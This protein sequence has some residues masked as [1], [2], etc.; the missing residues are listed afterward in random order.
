M[1]LIK[2]SVKASD[3][4]SVTINNNNFSVAYK[5]IEKKTVTI[6]YE[7]KAVKEGSHKNIVAMTYTGSD[8][9]NGSVTANCTVKVSGK[10]GDGTTNDG[11]EGTEGRPNYKTGDF[12]PY[13]LGGVLIALLAAAYGVHRRRKTADAEE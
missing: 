3:K 2:D 7:A 12:L 11:K 1:A 5:N 10:S 8:S 13:I 9:K 6:T 4:G